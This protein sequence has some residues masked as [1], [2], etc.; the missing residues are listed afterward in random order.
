MAE[1]ADKSQKRGRKWKIILGVIAI[2]IVASFF[3]KPKG[4]AS[5]SSNNSKKDEVVATQKKDETSSTEDKAEK[6]QE[7]S[8]TETKAEEKKTTEDIPKEYKNALRKAEAYSKQMYMS[9]SAIYEQLT[10][11]YGEKF[12]NEAA[13]YAIDNLNADYNANAL[14]KAKMYEEKMAMSPDAIYD[15]L[16][17]EYGERFT[18]EEAQY[19]IDHLNN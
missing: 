9:K 8:K 7:E 4:T 17:S 11:E 14:A 13:Q 6:K 15:Q 16:T 1:N 3:A 19:A 10:S 2:L 12:S 18:A 5:I